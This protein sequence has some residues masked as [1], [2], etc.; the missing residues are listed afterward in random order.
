M[1]RAR[2]LH[3]PQAM[4]RFFLAA[5]TATLGACGGGDLEDV[6]APEADPGVVVD[7]A[8]SWASGG[9]S[10]AGGAAG[11]AGLAGAP[12]QA[13][14]A[15][16]AGAPAADAGPTS[17]APPATCPRVRIDVPAGN[18]ANVRPDPSTAKAPLG[19]LEPGAIVDV[20][21]FVKGEAL[22][23][24]DLWYQIKTGSLSGFVFSGLAKCTTDE[25]AAT[26]PGFYLPL[27]CGKSATVTQGNFGSYS[28][29]GLSAYAYD[30]SLGI[31][32]PMT[33]MADG[34]VSY[35]YDKTGPGDPCYDGG[36]SSC[37]AYANIV[38]LQHAD[39][40]K[41]HYA[42]LSK[43]L[44]TK[45]QKVTRGQKVGLSGSTGYSTGPHAHVAR[46][47]DGSQ[48]IKLVFQDVPGDGM[49]NT[50]Q[51]VTSGNCP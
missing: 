17:T 29:Q 4:R 9:A 20:I 50:G 26:K 48:S 14:A 2:T 32:T 42:H 10:G 5:L 43:V 37:I 23:G 34:T 3:L 11:A 21:A 47:K 1:A 7:D 27:V 30:F 28:H 33:A 15:G 39:G 49:P 40:T 41:T 38:V 35:V 6:P 24:N 46:S 45:G 31:G 13:G 16:E 12:G 18:V 22:D 25:P 44:V 36:G 19:T 8:G 51:K